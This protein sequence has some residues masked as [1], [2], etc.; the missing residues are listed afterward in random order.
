MRLPELCGPMA[1]AYPGGPVCTEQLWTPSCCEKLKT[2]NLIP[3]HRMR[4]VIKAIF[5]GISNVPWL[6]AAVSWQQLPDGVLNKVSSYLTGSPSD[7]EYD[8]RDD[9]PDDEYKK[10]WSFRSRWYIMEAEVRR[11]YRERQ[12]M[13]DSL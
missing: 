13:E 5:H 4:G 8:V 2:S 1:G 6:E 12:L 7:D 9:V 10:V 3:N 11:C